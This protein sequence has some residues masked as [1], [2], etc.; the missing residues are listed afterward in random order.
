MAKRKPFHN[1]FRELRLELPRQRPTPKP[2]PPPTAEPARRDPEAELF[3]RAVGEVVPVRSRVN[4]VAPPPRE[5]PLY[6]PRE[7]DEEALAELC[8]LVAGTAPFD[9]AESDEYI[10]GAVASLD[11]RLLRRLRR[12]E[13][14]IQGHLDLHGYSRKEAKRALLLFVEESRRQ[15]KRCVLVIHGRGLHSKDQIPVLKEGMQV[16]LTKGR[17]G[18]QVLAFTTAL[19]HDGG[20]GAVYVLLR[21]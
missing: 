13:Y 2:A 5:K 3:L 18:A 11:R 14:A 19:P 6:D 12:G 17:L 9:L 1:P 16:W 10:E 4:V 21:R 15:G 7:D 8:E 20:A